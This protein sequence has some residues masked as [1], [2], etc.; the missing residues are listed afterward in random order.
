MHVLTTR[1]TLKYRTAPLQT[2]YLI[3]TGPITFHTK[4]RTTKDRSRRSLTLW[5]LPRIASGLHL[6]HRAAGQLLPDLVAQSTTNAPERRISARARLLSERASGRGASLQ[7]EGTSHGQYL[8]TSE[9]CTGTASRRDNGALVKLRR[10]RAAY[11]LGCGA[12]K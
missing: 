8:G 6:S 4:F 1:A 3:Q 10:E 2:N 12:R 5:R 7:S 11:G 9:H